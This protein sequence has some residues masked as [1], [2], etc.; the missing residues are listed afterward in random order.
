MLNRAEIRQKLDHFN[1]KALMVLTVALR[2]PL[3]LMMGCGYVNFGGK[4]HELHDFAGKLTVKDGYYKE[5]YNEKIHGPTIG[6][7]EEGERVPN[8][9]NNTDGRVPIHR[10]HG[11]SSKGPYEYVYE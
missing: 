8:L 3:M 10:H 4:L 6:F 11:M 7:V 2:V 5:P 1:R 9:K